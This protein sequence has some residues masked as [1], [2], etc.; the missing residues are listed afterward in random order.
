MLSTWNKRPP[1]GSELLSTWNKALLLGLALFPGLLRA[2]APGASE[3]SWQHA[4]GLWLGGQ[5]SSPGGTTHTLYAV[6][7]GTVQLNRSGPERSHVAGL[8]WTLGL[9]DRLDRFL[10]VDGQTIWERSIGRH[11]FSIG[12]NAGGSLYYG[13]TSFANLEDQFILSNALTLT[14][15]EGVTSRWGTTLNLADTIALSKTMDLTLEGSQQQSRGSVNGEEQNDNTLESWGVQ[16][17]KRWVNARLQASVSQTGLQLYNDVDG[18]NLQAGQDVL[19]IQARLLFPLLGRLNG[20]VGWQDLRS[21]GSDGSERRLSGPELGFVY[22]PRAAWSATVFARAL[23][24]S[25][26]DASDGQIFGEANLTY[27]RDARNSFVLGFSRQ[28][29]LTTAYRVFTDQNVVLTDEQRYTVTGQVQWAY[30]RGR[31]NMTLSLVQSEQQFAESDADYMEM[32]FNQTFDITRRGQLSM[33]LGGRSSRFDTDLPP[34]TVDRFFAEARIGWQE[35]LTGGLRPLGGRTFYRLDV[36]YENL[37]EE[38]V[39]VTADRLTLLVSLGQLGN[40]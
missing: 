4:D 9:G 10:V 12:L 26:N 23:R 5:T 3:G 19:D 37:Q 21:L 6:D 17:D 7:N 1:P 13:S 11:R 28:I 22:T 29:D 40:F 38:I 18:Q 15:I 25:G 34:V 31:Y 33:Q 2:Q 14:R 32:N 36:S 24:E 20:S 27:Q 30:A 35:T 8:N 16:L 39:A